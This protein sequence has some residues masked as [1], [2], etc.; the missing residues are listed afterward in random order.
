V[1][2]GD[3]IS[4]RGDP[5]DACIR[6]L[7]RLKTDAGVFGCMGN[8]ERYARAEALTEKLGAR[9]GIRFLRGEKQ[10]LRF[11]NSVLNLAGVDFQ[12]LFQKTS[13]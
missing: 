1:V 6:Q 8:H 13:T 7:S 12:S 9:A 4:S 11:G 10:Q 3:L 5:L 2:T